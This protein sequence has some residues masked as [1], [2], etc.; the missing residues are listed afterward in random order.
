MR[1]ARRN[2]ARPAA[3]SEGS[4]THWADETSLATLQCYLNFRLLIFNPAAHFANQAAACWPELPGEL[5]PGER[6][7]DS[8]PPRY[9]VLKHTHRGTKAQHYERIHN[10]ER[11]WRNHKGG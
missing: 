4:R 8:P 11:V 3:D 1:D 2:I 9:V 7:A 6:A 5:P 10:V